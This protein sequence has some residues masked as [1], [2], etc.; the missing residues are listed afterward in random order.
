MRFTCFLVGIESQ[1][2]I[3]TINDEAI[4]TSRPMK[5]LLAQM[6][7]KLNQKMHKSFLIQLEDLEDWTAL[8]LQTLPDCI[9]E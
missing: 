2:R 5:V 8:N 9:G 7:L 4:H 3:E 6:Q 1:S